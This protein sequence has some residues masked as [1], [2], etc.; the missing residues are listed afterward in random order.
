MFCLRLKS[1]TKWLSWLAY[2][3]HMAVGKG[4]GATY[5]GT[6]LDDCMD[7]ETFRNSFY[8]K[9]VC[10]FII[11]IRIVFNISILKA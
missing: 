3:F 7:L 1:D 8:F 4:R 11:Q 6:Q 10:I 5:N 9:V 2:Q